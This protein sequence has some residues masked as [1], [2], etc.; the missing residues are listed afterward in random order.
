MCHQL[1]YQQALEITTGASNF[2]PGSG[3]IHF[4]EVACQGSE[5]NLFMCSLSRNT[6]A[7]LHNQDAGVICAGSHSLQIYIII[8]YTSIAYYIANFH[9]NFFHN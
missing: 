4:Q 9:S 8:L 3:P 1:G 5:S 2:G 6:S 7:C